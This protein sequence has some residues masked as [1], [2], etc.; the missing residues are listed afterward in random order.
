MPGNKTSVDY[1]VFQTK[2]V[3]VYWKLQNC[4]DLKLNFYQQEKG[5]RFASALTDLT[6]SNKIHRKFG[7]ISL[8]NYIK[9]FIKK[10]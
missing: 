5:E 8:K 6:L 9:D 4:L 7:A 2:K 10:Y 3:T 1:I